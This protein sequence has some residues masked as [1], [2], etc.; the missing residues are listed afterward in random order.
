MLFHGVR[1]AFDLLLPQ[2][3]VVE[4]VGSVQSRPLQQGTGGLG[5]VEQA[6]QV[7]ADHLAVGALRAIRAMG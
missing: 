4:R 7:G 5:V 3:L 2:C 6:V 1:E